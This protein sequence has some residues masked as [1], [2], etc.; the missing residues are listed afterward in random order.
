VLQEGSEI[1][2]SYRALAETLAKASSDGGPDLVYGTERAPQRPRGG[3]NLS[4]A[5]AQH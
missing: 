1:S 3:L 2:R 5:R 4:P